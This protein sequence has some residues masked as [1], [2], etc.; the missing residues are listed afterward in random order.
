MDLE[1]NDASVGLPNEYIEAP[2]Q[3]D[4]LN[5]W[6][7]MPHDLSPSCDMNMVIYVVV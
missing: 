7:P 2:D 6:I 1:P 5:N 4:E 3:H